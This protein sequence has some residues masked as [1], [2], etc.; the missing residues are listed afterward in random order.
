[1]KLKIDKDSKYPVYRQIVDQISIKIHNNELDIEERLPTERELSI[2]TGISRGTIKRAYDELS[3]DGIIQRIQGSGTFVSNK[4]DI[5]V[6]CRKDKAIKIINKMLHE[7]YSMHLTHKEIDSLISSKIQNLRRLTTNIR[8]A[9]VDEFMETLGLISSQLYRIADVDVSEFLLRNL[10]KSPQRLTYNYDII[11]TTKNH[12]LQV[13]EMAPSIADI[14]IKVAIKPSQRVKFELARIEENMSVGIWC[15]SQE[16]ANTI[17]E[18][19]ALMGHKDIFVDFRLDSEP[20]LVI[21]FIK[22][23]DIIII[24]ND[25]LGVENTQ[26][27]ELLYQ[28]E[29]RG[30]KIIFFEYHIDQGSLLHINYQLEQ[31]RKKKREYTNNVD[32]GMQGTMLS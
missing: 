10:E 32:R 21:N 13:I 8:I 5:A 25:Y 17:Y 26:D 19:I 29:R 9:V 23:K 22:D 31:C 15:M 28:F 20:G 16:F 2:I 7:L 12:Y 18:H 14:V 3:S 6:L 11:L 1:M 30:G 24:P 27:V 4:Q